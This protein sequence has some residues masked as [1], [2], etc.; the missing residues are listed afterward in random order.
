MEVIELAHGFDYPIY[1]CR[2]QY[3][4]NRNSLIKLP[5][6]CEFPKILSNDS[7]TST[8]PIPTKKI[9]KKYKHNFPMIKRTNVVNVQP[10]EEKE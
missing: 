9:I 10:L 4:L 6:A 2:Y 5:S 8:S 3:K 7:F 1:I